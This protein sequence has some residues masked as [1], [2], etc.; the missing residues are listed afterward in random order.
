MALGEHQPVVPSVFD[1]SAAAVFT[2]RCCK[3][4]AAA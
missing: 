1:Q 4:L 3:L 2:S